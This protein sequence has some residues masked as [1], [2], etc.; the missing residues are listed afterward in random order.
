[1]LYFCS[2]V[3]KI[4]TGY[5][6]PR[7]K[8]IFTERILNVWLKAVSGNHPEIASRFFLAIAIRASLQ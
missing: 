4:N 5:I 3:Q 2:D 1:M 7:A 6:P 8:K